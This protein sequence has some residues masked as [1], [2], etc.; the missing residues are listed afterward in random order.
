MFQDFTVL[1]FFMF[2]MHTAQEIIL[3]NTNKTP[4]KLQQNNNKIL[5]QLN[6]LLISKSG[7]LEKS[8]FSVM[9]THEKATY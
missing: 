9:I 4:P 2:Y 5:L 8:N 7:L 6:L 1:K 3:K